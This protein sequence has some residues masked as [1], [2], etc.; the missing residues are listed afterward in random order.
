MIRP[1]K[2]VAAGASRGFTLIELLV[3]IAIIAIL[4]GLLLP[5]LASAKAKATR[6]QC[7]GN[8]KQWGVAVTLYA[9]DNAERFPDNTGAPAQDTA[10]MA[11]SFSNFYRAY[12]YPNRPG[13]SAVNQRSKNDVLYCPTDTW[14]RFYEGSQLTANLIGYN[15]LPGRLPTGGVS[16][17]YNLKGL[18][19]WFTRKK[20]GGPYRRAPIIMDKLQQHTDG[21]W[22]TVFSG[23]TEPDSS[24]RGKASVP[25]GGNSLYE[26]G[27]T[28]WLKFIYGGRPGVSATGSRIE[29][30]TGQPNYYQFLK[31]VELTA[32]PW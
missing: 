21:R 19:A 9:G 4:A 22:T 16:A 17:N 30:G 25:E 2:P 29:V 3:V 14:H 23:Q 31:P 1:L 13:T 8:L 32:G 11:H 18:V 20:L 10:W 28:E 26:D 6:I 12:L 5:A 24:H 27:H 7:A 15:Y